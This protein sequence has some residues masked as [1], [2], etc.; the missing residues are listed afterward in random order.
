[1]PS[2]LLSLILTLRPAAPAEAPAHLGRAAHALLLR[3]IAASRPELAAQLHDAQGPKPITAS[4]LVGLRARDGLR[5]ERTYTLRFTA[6]EAEAAQALVEAAAT[7]GPLSVGASV[8]LDGAALRVESPSPR[9]SPIGR[10]E[11]GEGH[12][13][14]GAATYESLS[15]P[16]LL[17]RSA[18]DRRL[19]L[20][21]A[22]PTTF[23][24]GG[25][26]VPVPMPG[27]VF[28]SLLEKW[29]AF[30]PVALP[31]EVR[32]FAS[33]CL[34]LSRYELRTVGL[35]FKDGAMK[36]GAVGRVTYAALNGDRYWLS[37]MSLLADFAFYAG[38][39]AGTAM[40]MG[41]CRRIGSWISDCPTRTPQSA[42]PDPKSKM[43]RR[44][45]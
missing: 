16:W 45:L 22:S 27:W 5:P 19:S 6:I 26:N 12:P 30:A 9:P 24:S 4:S 8:E 20:Q 21:F 33:E 44:D 39:G 41:Q 10:G 1:M 34:A 11:G 23:K 37:L 40:G 25:M 35:P 42:I 29:N 38:V 43:E 36:V 28:G 31:P 2:S 15:A 3:A 14:A 13:W 17:G 7:G 32:R 18:P